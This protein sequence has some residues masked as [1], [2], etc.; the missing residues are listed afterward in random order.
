[1][2]KPLSMGYILQTRAKTFAAGK[3]VNETSS[4]RTAGSRDDEKEYDIAYEYSVRTS[5]GSR[6]RFHIVARYVFDDF[7][8]RTA[9]GDIFD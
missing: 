8:L 4:Q 7:S 5:L 9:K 1:M 2:A 3:R 6:A